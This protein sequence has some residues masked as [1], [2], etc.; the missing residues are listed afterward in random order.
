MLA[1]LTGAH[2][3]PLGPKARGGGAAAEGGGGTRRVPRAGF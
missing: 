2:P 1:R 3:A